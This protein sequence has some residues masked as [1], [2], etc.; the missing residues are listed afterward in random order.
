MKIVFVVHRY[1]PAVGGVEKYI[2]ELA[3]ALLRMGH[4]VSIVAGAHTDGLPERDRHDDIPVLRYPAC[5]SALRTRLWML[6]HVSLFRSADVVHVSNTHVLELFWRMVGPLVDPRK[7][8][9][10]RHGMS[11]QCPVPES[12]KRRAH[13]S[14]E[15]AAGVI[16]DG[17]FIE[18]WLG[19]KPDC[20]PDQGLSPSTDELT[21][22]P[23]PPPTSA[24]YIGRLEPDSGIGIY[25]DAVRLLVRK[26]GRDFSMQV[27]GDGSLSDTLRREVCDQ[28]LPVTFH[29]RTPNAQA[30]IA[31]ACFAFIDGRM[32]MQEAMARRRL[33]F[34]A[35]VDPLKRDYVSG[36]TF[37]PYLIPVCTAEGL[38]EKVDFYARH[39]I[40]RANI[41]ERAYAHSRSLTWRRTAEAYVDLWMQRL[42]SPRPGLTRRA[43]LRQMFSLNREPK[44]PKSRWAAGWTPQVGGSSGRMTVGA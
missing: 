14:L 10:T 36:E 15:L 31:D 7:V 26:H 34:A 42:A 5:R 9:L 35:Y 40:E 37:S 13:R 3:G 33:V 25:L 17:A 12:E 30:R 24:A 32:A 4:T 6:R 23:E 22:V 18:P 44:A 11:Y 21:F 38:A 43:I 39:P 16:H 29:G 27:Y 8:F 20:C 41:I 28:S 1:W 2:H 19:V